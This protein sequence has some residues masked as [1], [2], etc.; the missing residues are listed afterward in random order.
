MTRRVQLRAA[1][2]GFR[3]W[4]PPPLS[5]KRVSVTIAQGR[6]GRDG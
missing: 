6:E 5:E 1:Q 3:V 4:F 2:P